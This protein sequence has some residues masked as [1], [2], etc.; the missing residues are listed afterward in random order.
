M[1][2][3]QRIQKVSLNKEAGSCR[4]SD[5]TSLHPDNKFM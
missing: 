1:I 5:L 2:K 3:T 4:E